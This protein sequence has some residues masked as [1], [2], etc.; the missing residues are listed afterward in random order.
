M[1]R[2]L[3][4]HGSRGRFSIKAKHLRSGASFDVVVN[5]VKVGSLVTGAR[6]GGVAR[7]NTSPKPHTGRLGFD[8]RGAHVAVREHDTGMDDLECDMPGGHPDSAIGCCVGERKVAD[9]SSGGK[10][11]LQTP[12]ACTA[13][14]GRPT[15]ATACLPDP[16][17]GNPPPPTVVCCRSSS[18]DGAF[19]DDDPQVI[20]EDDVTEAECADHGG[21]VVQA[22]S[23]QSNP[24]QPA[25]PP[26]MVI[27]CVPDDEDSECE[28]VTRQHCSDAGGMVSDA[29][30]CDCHPCGNRDHDGDDEDDDEHD[31][32]H[33]DGGGKGHDGHDGHDGGDG[34]GDGD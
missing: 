21:M 8:P 28:H 11:E 32:H 12:D 14:G 33:G 1:A 10:C 4:K 25:P 6:G 9:G 5:G 34:D 20:C 19:A 23:C 27:C 3:L 31:G 24:C 26:D 30:S 18:A 17:G 29:K 16:C 2:V 7:F 13:R 22:S 15:T